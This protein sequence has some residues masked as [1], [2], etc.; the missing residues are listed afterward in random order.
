MKRRTL[1]LSGVAV[2]LGACAGPE[3]DRSA[4]S[5]GKGRDVFDDQLLRAA[6]TGDAAKVQEAVA[7]GADLEVRDANRRTPLLLA[8]A[9]DHVEVAKIL[10][11]AGADPDALDD[12]SD[13]P[14]LVTG[15]TGSVAMLK[16]LL[17]AGP[18]L[19]IRNRY[20][21]I[22]LIPAC[23]RGHVDYVREVLKTDI[24]VDH[25]NNLGWTGLLEAVIL[26]D[27]SK[28]YQEIVSLLIEAGADVNLADADGVTPLTRAEEKGF[29]EIA[30]LLRA[31]GG[32]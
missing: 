21:G 20:G 16:V 1:L 25:V 17:A 8:S 13:T 12:R 29:G 24:K 4:P 31:A 27:G 32:R 15:V 10:V 30:E 5:G 28:P 6:A 14:W 2:V 9:G 23:E 19:T 3:P 18:D 26:G 11:S 22:S 7:G